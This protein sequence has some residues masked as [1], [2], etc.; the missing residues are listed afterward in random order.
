MSNRMKEVADLFDLKFNETFK[1]KYENGKISEYN[2]YINEN[3]F[4]YNG[5]LVSNLLLDLLTGKD[6]VV[7]KPFEPNFGEVY[8]TFY[9]EDNCIKV[10]SA[11][12]ENKFIDWMFYR[13]GFCFK[14]KKRAEKNI[15]KAAKYA[16]GYVDIKINY[17]SDPDNF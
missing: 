14:T 16:N 4:Y 7:Y 11:K 10:T 6:Q 15:W 1:L 3:G 13:L 2:C 5:A 12:W 9:M 8:W 17:K